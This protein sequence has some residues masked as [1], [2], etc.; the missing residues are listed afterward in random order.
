MKLAIGGFVG[1][2]ALWWVGDSSLHSLWLS[3]WGFVFFACCIWAVSNLWGTRYKAWIPFL[4]A[5]S[6]NAA[7]TLFWEPRFK[8][9][10]PE[11]KLGVRAA[12]SEAYLCLLMGLMFFGFCDR[13][14]LRTMQD[15]FVVV[16]GLTS[17]LLLVT[18]QPNR[19]FVPFYDNPSM[20]AS[21]VAVTLFLIPRAW[22]GYVKFL[23]WGVGLASILYTKASTPITA[24]L[25]GWVM[26]AVIMRQWAP[27][28]FAGLIAGGAC[29]VV[30]WGELSSDSGRL[31]IWNTLTTFS[32]LFDPVFG[33]GLGSTRFVYPIL[34]GTEATR[35]FFWIHN[36]WLQ[37][38]CE[39]G[40]LGNVGL[41]WVAWTWY[42]TAKGRYDR[43]V[44]NAQ[45]LAAGA[46]FSFVMFTNFPWHWP[47][48]AVLGG[49][50]VARGYR[51]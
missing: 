43:G 36:D 39:L 16:G 31:Q 26:V 29:L 33:T 7:L 3:K 44:E 27:V 24:L 2:L 28:L 48:H 10:S 5:C 1:V 19:S 11:F 42:S 23:L 35:L 22:P 13:R 8:D 47:V 25:A 41:T 15:A 32:H 6:A 9:Y 49:V 4:V 21:L 46:A 18:L 50:L 30:P 38:I 12:A 20:A 14:W 45:L 34:Q 51:G 37:L 17:L 40:F